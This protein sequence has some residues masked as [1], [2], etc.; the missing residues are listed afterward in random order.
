MGATDKMKA[1]EQQLRTTNLPTLEQA[2][3][4]TGAAGKATPEVGLTMP[5]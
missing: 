2:L 5:Q 3:A 1:I 4:T